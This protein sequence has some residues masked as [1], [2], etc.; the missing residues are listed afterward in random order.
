MKTVM[1]DGRDVLV[2][3]QLSGEQI[4]GLAQCSDNQFAVVLREK[5]GVPQRIPVSR[6]QQQVVLNNGDA[7]TTQYRVPNGGVGS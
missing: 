1:V 6:S 4:A 7:I 5:N 3:D 2:E